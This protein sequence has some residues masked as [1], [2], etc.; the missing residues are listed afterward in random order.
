MDRIAQGII[1]TGRKI[2]SPEER[3]FQMNPRGIRVTTFSCGMETGRTFQKGPVALCCL[4]FF[5]LGIMF[6][7]ARTPAIP[8]T[9]SVL[10][11]EIALGTTI[12]REVLPESD[13]DFPL[14]ARKEDSPVQLVTYVI[15]KGDTLSSIAVKFG[16]TVDSIAFINNLTSPDRIP[17]GEELSVIQNASGA[18]KRVVFGNTLWSIALSYGIS[19][20]DIVD[21]NDILDPNDLVEGQLLVLP[22]AQLTPCPQASTASRSG[23]LAWPLSGI[24]TSSF[25]WR[26]HPIGGGTRFHEGI[27]IAAD[28]GTAVKAA[29]SGTVTQASWVGGYGRLVILSHGN[30][31]ETRYAHLTNYAVKVGQQVRAGDTVGYVGQSGDATGPHCHFEVR[32][33]GQIQNPREYLP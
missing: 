6:G 3:N 30:G 26:I 16:T 27:D 14:E 2:T 4:G 15:Q 28:T 22:G 1:R 25:G 11:V 20:N 21:A 7:L 23:G 29:A 17:V 18:V 10:E 9:E 31:L 13:A 24:I 19:V 8:P 12:S 33:N 32:K 5:V